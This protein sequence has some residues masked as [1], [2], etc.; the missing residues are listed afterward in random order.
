MRKFYPTR[1]VRNFSMY[2]GVRIPVESIGDRES[3]LTEI[4]TQLVEKSAKDK[5]H[6][7]ITAAVNLVSSIRL[8]PLAIKQPIAKLVYG[9]LGEKIYTTTFSNLG[10][11]NLP[12]EFA[13]YVE[14]MDFCLGAQMTNR[15]AC[16]AVTY[17]GVSTFS[18]SKMTADPTFEERMYKLLTEDGLEVSVEG[19]EYYA[20]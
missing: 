12:T 8:I 18:I 19:S 7:M 11:V 16:T 9:F 1:T 5:M 17:G 6:E 3:L 2:C 4:S 20:H 14:C 15:L 10:V 13:D